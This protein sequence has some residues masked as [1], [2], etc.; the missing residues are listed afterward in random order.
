MQQLR[1]NDGES[2]FN[3]KFGV[4]CN[5]PT[6][7]LIS[8]EFWDRSDEMVMIPSLHVVGTE[9]EWC[10]EGQRLYHEHFDSRTSSLVEFE[11]GHRM[12]ILKEHNNEIVKRI[13]AMYKMS[14]GKDLVEYE[15]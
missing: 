1:G 10:V 14:T 9:D 15:N 4:I 12:P 13:V 7:P 5:S 2:P 3:F 6:P 11:V 8:K